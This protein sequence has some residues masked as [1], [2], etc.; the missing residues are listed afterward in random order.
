[1][2]SLKPAQMSLTVP[3]TASP[4][5]GARLLKRYASTPVEQRALRLA[6]LVLGD[7]DRSP[8]GWL[9]VVADD[10]RVRDP[11][12]YAKDAYVQSS[13]HLLRAYLYR[14]PDDVWSDARRVQAPTL[15]LFGQRDK[16]VP[17]AVARRARAEFANSRLFFM[18]E[19]G[20]VS[21]IEYPQLTAE[22]WSRFAS[23]AQATLSR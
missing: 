3:L 5:L 23:D 15:L 17:L 16:L 6:T 19:G 10:L 2:P 7:L 9:D 18:P 8:A 4:V 11:L 14:G 20:H 13:R 21:Q 12:P 1:M 22:A